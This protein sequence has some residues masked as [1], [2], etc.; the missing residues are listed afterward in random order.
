M[1]HKDTLHTPHLGPRKADPFAFMEGGDHLVRDGYI[2]R[3][4]IRNPPGL[5]PQEFIAKGEYIHSAM[6]AYYA[7]FFKM[8]AGQTSA[9]A[10][11]YAQYR[12]R[13]LYEIA[14]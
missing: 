11:K 5:L 1:D 4:D 14:F 6:I 13:A 12:Y 9:G 7:E 10:G 2:F 3:A 8:R